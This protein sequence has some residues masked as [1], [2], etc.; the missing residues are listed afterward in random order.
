[1][2][3]SY[4][5]AQI[6]Q[7]GG[8]GTPG[9][10]RLTSAAGNVVSSFQGK[11]YRDSSGAT[12]PGYTASPPST[13]SLIQ[14]TTFTISENSSYNGTY[15]V[16]TPV[17]A[18][19]SNPSSV[20]G[21]SQTEVLVNEVIGVPSTA[22]DALNTGT[23]SN[24]STYLLKITGEADL[25]VPPTVIFSNRP[26]DIVGR[27]GTPWGESFAQNF[28]ELAQNS[29]AASAPSNPFLGQTW[30]DIANNEFKLNGNAGWV[31]MASGAAGANTT[32]RSSVQTGTT[33]TINHNLG[34]TAP[35][36]ALVQVFIDIGGG[37]YKMILPSDITFVSS[38]QITIT[39]TASESGIVLIRA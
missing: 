28:L 30:Y 31:V 8:V 26:M 19:D 21:A 9:R 25:V 13:Y 6:T 4:S 36:I 29:A 22:S 2:A 27:N 34:L 16:Y 23:V 37:V 12:L 5:I 3:R 1:M 32:Y 38:N 24:I 17:S 20:Y 35:Y 14:A 10:V 39:F 7:S 18:S 11:F 33:W 15:T